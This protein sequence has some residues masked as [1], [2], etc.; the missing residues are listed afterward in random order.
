MGAHVSCS[1][2]GSIGISLMGNFQNDIPSLTQLR[3]LSRLISALG[4]NYSLD[5]TTETTFHGKKSSAV[6]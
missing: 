3:S 1:N 5:P 2:I 4:N 6:L